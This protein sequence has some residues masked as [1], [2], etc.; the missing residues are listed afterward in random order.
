MADYGSQQGREYNRQYN[1]VSDQ[2][3]HGAYSAIFGGAPSGRAQTM[4]SSTFQQ[5]PDR[6]QTMSSQGSTMMQRTPPMRQQMNGYERPSHNGYPPPHRSVDNT[7]SPPHQQ[8]RGSPTNYLPNPVPPE[9]KPYGLP[10]RTD[11]RGPPM[12]Q[13]FNRPI[14]N[15]YPGGPPGP[16]LN[17]D[18]YRSQSLAV[19]S[20]PTYPGTGTYNLAPAQAFRQQAYHNQSRTTAQ[21]RVVP[22]RP[23]ERTMSLAAYS[24]DGDHSHMTQTM[25]GR[26]IPNRRR[27]SVGQDDAPSPSSFATTSPSTTST[28]TRTPSQSSLPSRT[29]SMAS[30]IVAPSDRTMS[31]ASRSGVQKSNSNS[32]SQAAAPNQRRAPLVYPALLSKVAET[33]RDKIPLGDKIKDGLD[34]KGAFAGAEAVDLIAYIIK[35]NDRNLALLL[36]RSLDAQK[37]FHD[38][39]YAHRLRDS[40]TEVYRFKETLVETEDTGVNGVFTLLTECYSPTCTRDRLCYS[41]ACPRR[42]EQQAR[43]NM[44]PQAGLRREDSRG[45]LHEDQADEQKLWINTVS[46]EV[47]DSIDDKEKKRQEVISEL[48]YTERDFVKDLEY[49]RDFWMKPLRAPGTSPIPEHRREKLIKTIFS[50]CQDVYYVNSRLAES[51][52]RRQQQSPVVRNV[53]DIFL[54]YVPMFSPFITYGANQ[55]FGKYEFECERKTNAGF[56]KFVD[57]VERLKESRKLELNGYLTKPTTRL[58]RY[59]LLLENVLKYTADDNPDK[60]DIP[61]AIKMIKDVLSRVNIESGK[62][63]NR[64]NL[65]QLARELKFRNGEYIDL[66]L[67]DES[68]QLIYKGGLKRNPTDANADVQGFLFDHAVLLVRV[69]TVNKREEMKVYKKPIPLEL[70]VITQMDEVI[71][72]MG[73]AKRPSSS[74]VLGSKNNANT[75]KTEGF[76]ITF[77]HLGKGGYECTLYCS[78]HIQQVKWMEHIEAQ[79]KMIK[80]RNN[81]YMQTTLNEGFFTAAIRVNCCAPAD[82]GRKLVL[83]TDSG[84]YITDRKPKDASIKPRRILEAKFVSGIDVLEAHSILLVLTEKTMFTYPMEILHTEESP[85]TNA[86]RGKKIS[87]GTFFK[88][89][90]CDGQQL[91]CL[92]KSSGLSTT[93]K[94]YEPMENYSK[95]KKSG[96][97]KLLAGGQDVLKLSKEIY[98]PSEAISLHY[99]KTKLCVGCLKGFEIVEMETLETQSLLDQAD[100]SLDFVVARKESNI[101]PIHVERIGTEFLL[102]YSDFSFWVNRH[103]WRT[104]PEWKITWEG[105]PQNFAICHPYILAFEPSFVEIRH[106]DTGMLMHILTAKNIRMLHTST[107]EILYAYE[108]EL[109]YDVIASLDFWPQTKNRPTHAPMS[110][111]ATLENG[112]HRQQIEYR[113]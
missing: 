102:C 43:L 30:T 41:I 29:M 58:A 25:S 107:Q 91:V 105:N 19:G 56:A 62:A 21:G 46:K 6:S 106:I 31:M 73:I 97:G 40:H 52:T 69:K 67:T 110:E 24:R 59:P 76:P 89:G 90:I 88:A 13:S 45:S 14:P 27:E 16:A 48:M 101:K 12:G 38:V 23:D 100:T 9:R 17:S 71:P 108:D 74:L 109:G 55:L 47:A 83:G 99:L 60:D 96:F 32:T 82:S 28:K 15:R 54:E 4:S 22:E 61:K 7:P 80:D 77:K 18:P 98:I 33:F 8:Q 57:E 104:H 11:M 51:L 78:T 2:Q 68:R 49:L 103:G 84:V 10:P 92:V 95:Q 53:G 112:M 34:Y 3:R 63:E 42:L 66:K 111:K 94:V 50:N 70:L 26:V 79:C 113:Y 5:P 1:P 64:F 37:F 81:M 72:K 75:P 93:V 36:G 87:H 44:K 65:Q 39:T 86:K 20:R 85:V 35:T